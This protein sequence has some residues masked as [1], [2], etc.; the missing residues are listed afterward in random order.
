MRADG[1]GRRY[2]LQVDE[3]A[4]T[5][6]WTRSGAEDG[7]RVGYRWSGDREL[8]LRGVID[9]VATT[10]VLRREYGVRSALLSRGFHW[11]QEAPFNR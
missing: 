3:E 7:F 4:R 1:S 9:G 5:L 11:V 10:V 2:R 6:Q 8:E